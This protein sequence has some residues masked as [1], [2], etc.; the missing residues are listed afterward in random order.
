M[1]AP[2]RC[3][4]LGGSGT[5][6]SAVCEALAAAGAT[7]AFTYL[8]GDDRAAA[9]AARVRGA[10]A[11][12]ADLVQPAEVEAAVDRAEAALGG[13]DVLVHAAGASLGAPPDGRLPLAAVDVT[14]WDRVMAVNARAVFVAVRRLVPVF[15]RAGGGEV[16]L[17][18]SVD[19]VKPVAAPVHH[20]ASKAALRG[21]TASLAKELGPRNVRVNM[22]APGLL[23]G[24]LSREVPEELRRE[25]LVHSGARRFGKA[26]EI[27]TL[28]RFLA[29]ENTYVTGQALAADGGL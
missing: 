24:G 29:M 7:V 8:H 15:E 4:V 27:A 9:L 2:R 5:V 23:E 12:R 14:A 21:M 6:G 18:G 16:V 11:L 20:A 3:L 25:Y 1:S 28:V 19:A 17:I 22:V 10:V 26:A 13:L